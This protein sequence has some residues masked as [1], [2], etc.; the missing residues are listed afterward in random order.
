MRHVTAED[1]PGTRSRKF[2]KSSSVFSLFN[3]KSRSKF[4]SESVIRGGNKQDRVRRRS[5][6]VSHFYN[7]G[8]TKL[9]YW[10]QCWIIFTDFTIFFVHFSDFDD[11]ER[12]VSK[13][14]GKMA[15]YNYT[16]SGIF[17]LD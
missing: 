10:L 17:L 1:T 14:A 11:L 16:S 5:I 3:L 2:A 8:L 6:F 13:D 7:T 4:W 15:V 12:S 9:F